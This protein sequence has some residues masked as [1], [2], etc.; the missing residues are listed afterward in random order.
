MNNN[1]HKR[2]TIHYKECLAIHPKTESFKTSNPDRI[3]ERRNATNIEKVFYDGKPFDI[4]KHV[5]LYK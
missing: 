4:S 1:K 5:N 3:I 2:L